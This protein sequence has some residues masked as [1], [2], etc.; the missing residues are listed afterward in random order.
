MTKIPTYLIVDLGPHIWIVDY[1]LNSRLD[2]S[3]KID[4]QSE[5]LFS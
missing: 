1:I 3:G 4:A 5:I 2:F